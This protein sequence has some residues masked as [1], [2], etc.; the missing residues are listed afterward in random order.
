MPDPVCSPTLEADRAGWQGPGLPGGQRAWAAYR[1]RPRVDRRRALGGGVPESAP[2]ASR[3]PPQPAVPGVTGPDTTG[4]D[5]QRDGAHTTRASAVAFEAAVAETAR[6]R[7]LQEKA[8]R[9][10][11]VNS[12]NRAGWS[13]QGVPNLHIPSVH[14]VVG[15]LLDWPARGRKKTP[16]CR[17]E[18]IRMAVGSPAAPVIS[19]ERLPNSS[20][21]RRTSAVTGGPQKSGTAAPRPPSRAP[22]TR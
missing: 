6:R 10:I 13:P 17:F 20:R 8:P 19:P 2:T 9:F 11:D 18:I 15:E 4:L 12:K 5:Q 3:R 16:S 21:V 22:S 1:D 7:A 14:I